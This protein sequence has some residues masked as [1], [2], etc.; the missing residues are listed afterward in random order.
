MSSASGR[1][2]LSARVAAV[3]PKE[4]AMSNALSLPFPLR[5]G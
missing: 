2:S 3:E 1:D 4:V 5:S